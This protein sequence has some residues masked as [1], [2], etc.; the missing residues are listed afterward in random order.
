[1]G[2]K[3]RRVRPGGPAK[4]AAKSSP[5]DTGA[6]SKGSSL[7]NDAAD[8]GAASTTSKLCAVCGKPG[9]SSCSACRREFYCGP[10]CQRSHWSEH[11]RECTGRCKLRYT[12]KITDGYEDT[13]R[14]TEFEFKEAIQSK[15]LARDWT[16]IRKGSPMIAGVIDKYAGAKFALRDDWR[17]MCCAEPAVRIVSRVDLTIA[18]HVP[19]GPG[20]IG[21]MAVMD[22]A[23]CNKPECGAWVKVLCDMVAEEM[24][25]HV[26]DAK[27]E[28]IRT[29]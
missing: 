7:S 24:R 13:K 10:T 2:K 22:K 1:M 5:P 18:T 12:G 27:D 14:E 8:T 28:R 19:E 11:K 20:G 4:D 17:C 29:L 6:T 26:A 9:V 16:D 25:D 23:V 15:K 3:S 21:L